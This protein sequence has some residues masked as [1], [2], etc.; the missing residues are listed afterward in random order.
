MDALAQ[1][2]AARRRRSRLR[3]LRAS[4]RRLINPAADPRQTPLLDWIPEATPRLGRRP[5]VAPTWLSPVADAFEAIARGE[6]I[7]VVVNVP[8]QH[9]KSTIVAHGLIW[10]LARLPGIRL[11]FGT[12]SDRRAWRVS[13]RLKGDPKRGVGLLH[14]AGLDLIRDSAD[15]WELRNGSSAVWAGMGGGVTGEPGDVVVVD[16]TVRTR[17]DAESSVGRQNRWEWFTDTLLPTVQEGG[18]AIVVETRWHLDDVSGRISRIGADGYPF[19][20]VTLP[21]LDEDEVPLAPEIHSADD[22]RRRRATMDLYSWESLYQQNPTPRGTAAFGPAKFYDPGLL[23]RWG[24]MDYAVGIDL[25]YTRTTKADKCVAVVLGV[26]RLKPDVALVLDASVVQE[27]ADVWA[28]R[29]LVR[30]AARYPGASWLF[31]G[32]GGEVAAGVY[33]RGLG[34]PLRIVSASGD[35]FVRSLPAQGAHNRGS[36][37]WPRGQAWAQ[38][39][40][41]VVQRFTGN[42]DPEDD[43]VD[44]LAAA[45]DASRGASRRGGTHSTGE[46]LSV[47]LP[48]LEIERGDFGRGAL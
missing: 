22:L 26:P 7:F 37:L 45:W 2:D 36:I 32:Y 28:G 19:Q 33:V 46:A 41:R 20:F 17:A 35:K 5:V 8:R 47:R 31:Y 10:L 1:I 11:I 30:V 29:D 44:A 21:A 23:E 15:T 6:E 39:Y 13:H 40:L 27:R 3:E 43:E 16:D 48:G 18:S 12:Y 14:R 25:A 9:G 24:A 42:D 4:R 34:I 38:K